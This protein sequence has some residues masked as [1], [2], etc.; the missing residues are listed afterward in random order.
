[1][2]WME[3]DRKTCRTLISAWMCSFNDVFF[4]SWL[5]CLLLISLP[6][7]NL[8]LHNLR[9]SS[10]SH[11]AGC[12]G[13]TE[14]AKDDEVWENCKHFSHFNLW[15]F[16]LFWISAYSAKLKFSHQPHLKKVHRHRRKTQKSYSC[17]NFNFMW[18]W[19]VSK[20]GKKLFQSFLDSSLVSRWK[21]IE[22]EKLST[23]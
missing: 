4:I 10:E 3:N 16:S 20:R 9:S 8:F 12:V 19:R 6:D 21:M 14:A 5:G 2:R 13:L 1:M 18:M 22:T 17:M 7:F 11:Q 15:N 23:F